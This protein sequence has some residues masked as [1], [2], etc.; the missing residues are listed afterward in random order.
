MSYADDH[1]R[2]Y[3]FLKKC[4]I[5]QRAGQFVRGVVN[6]HDEGDERVH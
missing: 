2:R 4:D 6:Q 1:L 5:D 3:N